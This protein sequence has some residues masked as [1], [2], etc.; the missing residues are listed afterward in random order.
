MQITP[1]LKTGRRKQYFELPTTQNLRWEIL[2]L[3]T[4]LSFLKGEKTD[5]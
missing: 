3:L 4:L 5:L 1:F 2:S